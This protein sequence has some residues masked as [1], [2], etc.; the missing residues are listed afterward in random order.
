MNIL[1]RVLLAI[2]GFCLAVVSFITASIAINTE[3]FDSISDYMNTTV[4]PDDKARVIL[5]IVAFVFMV[6]SIMFLL[7]GI[8]SDKDKKSVSKYTNIGEVKISLHSIESIA[9]A[10]SRK[11]NGI[12]ETKAT[13]LKL[14]E[15]VSIIIKTII[16]GD[17]NVPAL[18]EDIQVKVKNSVEET[19]GIK[20]SDVKVLVE[21]VHT[22]VYKSRVG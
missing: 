1:F 9:L 10:A 17:I 20:V 18:S 19:T 8:K 14:Q 5:F 15:G 13:V 16:F 4:L 6:L 22:T 11:L 7:S 12:K 2:Y 21:N 3:I